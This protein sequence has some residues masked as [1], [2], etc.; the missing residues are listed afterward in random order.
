MFDFNLKFACFTSSQ[1]PVTNPLRV[2]SFNI[3]RELFAE[4]GTA[5]TRSDEDE[6]GKGKSIVRSFVRNLIDTINEAVRLLLFLPLLFGFVGKASIVS[7]FLLA[8]SL[9]EG[10]H[11]VCST[12]S[13]N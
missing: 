3:C 2:R 6:S 9:M 12:Q 5:K 11:Q 13:G 7:L 10:H 4:G 8:T 1:F